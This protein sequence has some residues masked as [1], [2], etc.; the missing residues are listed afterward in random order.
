M[1]DF[2][3]ILKLSEKLGEILRRK[4]KKLACVESCTGGLFAS[5]I[6]E[7]P[8]S[9]DYFDRG[10]ITYSNDSKIEILGVKKETIDRYGAVSKECAKEM[11]EGLK[12]ISKCSICVSITG[13]AGPTGGTIEKPVGLVYTGFVID[14]ITVVEKNIFSGSRR[15]VRLS[16]VDFVLKYLI[17]KIF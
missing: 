14:N 7:I 9:S 2:E 16:T 11:V 13:I 12:N 6:T 17:E 1:A 4:N 10:F 8:G 5:A 3:N 15:E